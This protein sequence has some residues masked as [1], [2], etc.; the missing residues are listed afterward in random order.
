MRNT[1]RDPRYEKR[2]SRTAETSYYANVCSCGPNFGDFFL[3]GEPGAAFFPLTEKEAQELT[4][5]EIP[6]KGEW[7]QLIKP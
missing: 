7:E 2:F 3:F 4:I 5:E 6:V 1:S